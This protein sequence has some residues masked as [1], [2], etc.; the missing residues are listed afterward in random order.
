M[1]ENRSIWE[2]TMS[3]LRLLLLFSI[4]FPIS[5]F[6]SS[7][8][9]GVLDL[10]LMENR[11][12]SMPILGEVSLYWKRFL[13]SSQL[14]TA[15]PSASMTLPGVWDNVVLN[16]SLIGAS[17]YGTIMF[18]VA[19]SPY[20]RQHL[21]ILLTPVFSS[22]RLY[23]D[24]TLVVKC[25]DPQRRPES[26]ISASKPKLAEFSFVGDTAKIIMHITNFTNNQ[27]GPWQTIYVGAKKAVFRQFQIHQLYDLFLLGGILAFT[28]AYF[29]TF[30]MIKHDRSR[31]ISLWFALYTSM[32]FIR[33]LTTSTHSAYILIPV[34]PTSLVKHLEYLSFFLAPLFYHCYIH[35]LFESVSSKRVMILVRYVALVLSG[36]SVLTPQIIHSQAVMPFQIF[37]LLLMVYQII[38]SIL[39]YRQDERK[40]A[41]LFISTVILFI[42]VGHDIAQGYGYGLTIP[43]IPLAGVATAIVQTYYVARNSH[44]MFV[45]RDHCAQRLSAVNDTLSCFVPN[46]FFSLLGK[47]PATIEVG[48]QIRKRMAVAF[49]DI[50]NLTSLSADMGNEEKFGFVTAFLKEVT[51]IFSRHGGFIDKYIGDSVMVIFPEKP[52]DSMKASLEILSHFHSP[53][54][55]QDCAKIRVGIG[56]HYGI[57][58]LGVIGA[59]ERMENTVIGDAVNTAS[60]MQ[61]LTHKFD[62]DLIVSNEVLSGGRFENE[63][64]H[65]RS[66]GALAVKGKRERTTI[67]EIFFVTDGQNSPKLES[68]NSFEQAIVF[69]E[70][71]QYAQAEQLFLQA[72]QVSPN[73]AAANAFLDS[74]RHGGTQILTT[75]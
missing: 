49:C 14:D 28:L 13:T 68:R 26:T 67:Q 35:L 5:T 21:A 6:A 9:S 45:E 3:A 54:L 2:E 10:S 73:D 15:T 47:S 61:S 7:L 70:A 69:Y 24:S 11:D 1:S 60:R 39:A 30:F 23:V 63:T 29:F 46:Q 22:Y 71:G 25:G 27:G 72:L 43:L 4:F 37:I 58:T 64:F 65:L 20:A 41:V 33:L 52:E 75:K 16:D 50:R 62:A 19:A 57:M 51:P 66:L 40:S 32:L 59:D 42:S 12:K 18:R 48:T 74:C 34:V 56:I 55:S 53:D 17:G 8:S 31:M 36:I 44:F 38:I